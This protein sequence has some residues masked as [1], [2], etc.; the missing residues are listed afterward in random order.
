MAVTKL[1][2]VNLGLTLVGSTVLTSLT[3]TGKPTK[4]VN[5]QF[6]LSA[7]GVFGLPINWKFATARAQLGRHG[8]DPAFGK[9]DYQYVL[10]ANCERV[11]A[12]VD[13]VNEDFHYEYDREVYASGN[14]QVD[15]VLVNQTTCYI[16]YILY[17]LNVGAWPGWFCRLVALDLAIFLCEPLKQDKQKKN[18]LYSLLTAPGTGILARAIQANGM[19]FAR[20]NTSGQNINEGNDDVLNASLSTLVPK[21]YIVERES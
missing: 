4:L 16:K 7:R 20:V 15:V 9:Y 21:R 17:R 10:P 6:E 13:P 11:I 12:V 14:T 1:D 2:V 19:E 3:G 5:S 8:T 18:Q